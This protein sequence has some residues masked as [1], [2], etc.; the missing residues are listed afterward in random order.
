MNAEKNKK[1]NTQKA[2]NRSTARNQSTWSSSFE[3][4]I[5]LTPEVEGREGRCSSAPPTTY[6]KGE[7]KLEK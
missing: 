2:Y 5:I 3:Y 7:S 1:E 4:E 6:G